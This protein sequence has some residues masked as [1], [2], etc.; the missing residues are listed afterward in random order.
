MAVMKDGRLVAT[1][2]PAELRALVGGRAMIVGRGFD[3]TIVRLLRLQPEVASISLDGD[4]LQIELRNGASL[5]PL[6][7]LLARAGAQIEQVRRSTVSL[8][9]AFV[10]LVA[11]GNA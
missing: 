7:T 10:A 4:H 3:D 9:E 6:V 8:E 2:S 5:A 1:G 11:K